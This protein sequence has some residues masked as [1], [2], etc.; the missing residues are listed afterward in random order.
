MPITNIRKQKL[1]IAFLT[2]LMVTLV[3]VSF[4]FA[5]N[6]SSELTALAESTLDTT[7]T[8]HVDAD[9][10]TYAESAVI[11]ASITLKA[12]AVDENVPPAFQSVANANVS[13]SATITLSG[14]VWDAVKS[15]RL[16]ARLVASGT[17]ELNTVRG[18][19]LSKNASYVV[20]GALQG[21]GTFNVANTSFTNLE[22][23]P[24]TKLNESNGATITVTYT[25]Q[26]SAKDEGSG[27]TNTAAET[28]IDGTMTFVLEL[29]FVKPTVSIDANVGGH[30]VDASGEWYTD[31]LTPAEV[32][33]LAFDDSARFTAVPDSGYYF[34]GWREAGTTVN[35]SGTVLNIGE[36]TEIALGKQP[37]F[38]AQFG[39]ISVREESEY[40]F[41]GN[42]LG[43]VIN[44]TAYTGVYY[45]TH[46]Y[47]GTANDGTDFNAYSEG[48]ASVVAGP[49]K[50]GTYTYKCD[51]FYRALEGDTVVSSGERIGGAVI[52][53]TIERNEPI[54]ERGGNESE[55]TLRL[56]DNLSA[57]DM[58]Y[59]ASNSVNKIIAISGALSIRLNGVDV[60]TNALLPVSEEGRRYDVHFI[61][62]DRDNY[63]EV[64]V[65]LTIYVRD[66][67]P[68]S[69]VNIES[70]VRDY[71]ISKSIVTEFDATVPANI[72]ALPEGQEVIKVSLRANM[73]DTSG[74]Y[75]FI[76]WRIGTLLDGTYAYSYLTAGEVIRDASG[77]ISAING[78]DFDYYMPYYGD[79][80]V[81][82]AEKELKKTASFQAIFVQDV[83]C[84]K[85]SN[86]INVSYTGAS[87]FLTPR[88]SPEAAGYQFGFG[89]LNYYYENDLAVAQ[90]KAPTAIG[91]HVLRYEIRNTALNT[92]VDVR[93]IN[94]HIVVATVAV[95]VNKI[96]SI[97]SGGYNEATGW[98]R[99]MSYDLSVQSLV[100][101]GA[102]KYYYS[103]DD[104][105]TWNEITSSIANSLGCATNFNTPS[106]TEACSVTNYL[107]MATHDANGV[108][109]IYAGYKVIARSTA[110][111]TAKIDTVSPTLSGIT[112]MQGGATYQAQW[113]NSMVNFTATASYGGS[114]AVIDVYYVKNGSWVALSGNVSH[115]NGTSTDISSGVE[116]VFNL[117]T[118]YEGEVKFRIRTG[119][120]MTSAE[121]E[122]FEIKIDK[123][124]PTF[125]NESSDQNANSLGWIGT[126]TN[127]TYTVADLGGAG[128]K[129][130]RAYL[131]LDGTGVN[132]A[133]VGSNKY[134]VAILDSREYT[135]EITDNAGNVQITTL[136]KNVDVESITYEY[137]ENS[138]TSGSWAHATAEV[139]YNVKVG[140]S[141]ARLSYSVNGGEYQPVGNGQYTDATVGS[142]LNDVVLSYGIEPVDEEETYSFKIQNRAGKE[143]I[144]DFGVI[145]F[146]LNAPVYTLLT[147][148][149][150]YQ[151]EEWSSVNL[152][153]EFTVVDDTQNVNSGLDDDS[154]SVDNGGTVENLGNGRYRLTIDKCTVYTLTIKD[155]AGNTITDTIQANVDTVTPSLTLNAY[156]GGGNPLDLNEL[157]TDEDN[158]VEN[159]YDFESWI[160]K[161]KEEPYVRIEFT[162]NLTAS[163]SRLEYSNNNG[164]TWTALTETYMP[165]PGEVSG[166]ISTRT[167]IT[168]EQNR[169]YKF[170]LATGSGRT[171]VYEHVDNKDLYVKL[172][173]T[174]PTL[175]SE[176]FR[177]GT[178]P[179]FPLKTTWINQTAQYRIMTADTTLGSGVDQ[180][181]IRLNI[182]PYETPD[183]DILNGTAVGQSVVM[184]V[185]GDYRTYDFNS[186]YKCLLTFTDKAGNAYEGEIFISH[187]DL[188]SGFSFDL[189]TL[190]VAN[191]V[192]SAW[193]EG[194]W[195]ADGENML[196]RATPV[197]TEGNGFG[198]SGGRLEVSI[199]GENW[200]TEKRL[201]GESVQ[202]LETADGYEFLTTA[203]QLYTYYFRLVTGAGSEYRL[204]R[205]YT[206]QKDNV[207]PT[208]QA[209][210][211]FAN[212]GAYGGEWTKEN[213]KFTLRALVG[214]AGGTLKVGK[215]ES[216]DTA[217]W[218][219]VQALAPNV[220]N[221]NDYYLTVEE[222]SNTTYFFKVVGLNGLESV[223]EAGIVVKLDKTEIVASTVAV[224]EGTPLESGKWVNTEA[225]IYPE[226]SAIGASGV[227]VVYVSVNGGE[228]VEVALS[229]ERYSVA[230]NG[231][232]S[233][234]NTYSFKIASVSGMEV[235]TDSFSLGYDDVAPTFTYALS[236]SQLP[237]TAV[238]ANRGWY[239]SDVDVTLTI[240]QVASGYEV[241]YAKKGVND[242][243]YGEWTLVY[244]EFTLTDSS[245]SGG[246]DYYYIF[247]VVSGS[248][249]EESSADARLPIDTHEYEA[250]VVLSVGNILEDETH[251]FATVTGTGKYK[252]G[253]TFTVNVT[254]FEGYILK[255]LYVTEF[256]VRTLEANTSL[257]ALKQLQE[258]ALNPDNMVNKYAG[259]SKRYTCTGSGVTLEYDYYKEVYL[260]YT[261]LRQCLQAGSVIAVGY[262]AQEEGFDE[263]F[264]AVTASETQEKHV[265]VEISYVDVQ[266]NA[267]SSVP[268]LIG[269]Y[270]FKVTPKDGY[271]NYYYM[272]DTAT[273]TVVYFEGEGT[274][275]DPYLIYTLEDFYHIDDY[276]HFETAD[277]TVDTRAYL[278]ANRREAY[279]KQM[280]DILMPSSFKPIASVG[281]G[282][283][284]AFSG[285]YNGNGYEFYYSGTYAV[286]GDFGIFLMLDGASITNL[287][288][289]YNVRLTGGNGASVGLISARAVNSSGI[290]A[291]YTIGNIYA[292]GTELNVGGVV[293]SLS[294]GIVSY[295]F[296]DVNITTGNADGAFG[297]VVGRADG[298]YTANVYTVSRLILNGST[299]YSFTAPSSTKF[300]YAGA[301]IGYIENFDDSGSKPSLSNK[302]YYLDKN[303]SFD[304]SIEIGL[305]LGNKETFGQY[306]E[307]YH[308]AE[309]INYFASLEE[310]SAADTLIVNV[311][312]R[313]YSVS[314]LEL[315]KI[316]IEDLKAQSGLKGDGTKENPFIINSE[317]LLSYVETFPY[318]EFKQEGDITLTVERVFCTSVPFVGVYDGAGY[319][320]LNAKA[321][322]TNDA[323]GGLFGVVAGTVK[324]LK[325]LDCEF[326]YETNGSLYAGGLVGLLE[327]GGLVENVIVTGTIDV[328]SG[329]E[330]AYA[331][332][333]VG[334]V[335]NAT[336]RNSL[337][338]VNVSVNGETMVVGGVCGHLQG[339]GLI[340]NVVSLSSLSVEYDKKANVGVAV[341]S[342]NSASGKITGLSYLTESA[343]A[344]GK[345]VAT[346]VGYSG[347]ENALGVTPNTYANLMLIEISGVTVGDKLKGLY[348]FSGSGT[349]LDPFLIASYEDL[350]LV[351]NYMYASFRLV[352]NVVIGDYNDD[353][354]LDRNDG[355]DY[356]YAPIGNGA[357]F[358]GSLDGSG[359]S[360]IGLTDSLFAVNAGAIS[361]VT[362]NVSYKVYARESDIPESDKVIDAKEG[363]SYTASKVAVRNEDILFGVAARINRTGGSL[364]RVSVSGEIYVRTL[365][366]SKV[367]FG[368]LVGVDMGGQVI[369]SQ[370]TASVSIRAS[371]VVAGGVI[372]EIRYS[373]KALTQIA[374]NFIQ[375]N[376][377]V[378]LGGASVTAGS[379][380]GYVAVF[381]SHAPNYASSTEIIVNG[382]NVGN[383]QYVG[384]QI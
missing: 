188:T 256:G 292:Q 13:E 336:I 161:A 121:S 248:G 266:G 21:K 90:S 88:F 114:G 273:L 201:N 115:S 382:E 223:T 78:L 126:V 295:S 383:G 171:V 297:G 181:S 92:T 26:N 198:L 93:E 330:I 313:N 374:S 211:A 244:E 312:E 80:S 38:V 269:T 267:S 353:G 305:S 338:V 116:A 254:P 270:T 345:N 82:E 113:T 79:E 98:A 48:T 95:N 276:M 235:V 155:I 19:A 381:H 306:A 106:V 33:D 352:D 296:S 53:F 51:F 150:A 43:P 76:G 144:I 147:D 354:I 372:G 208:V 195:L 8:T 350:T 238:E 260:S 315:V 179:N 134:R 291:S 99:L 257:E 197:F 335:N 107:F 328:V 363:V 50:A 34:M 101:K 366:Q 343:Y 173:F 100:S 127:V 274:L 319:S 375:I 317:E 294:H 183:E 355:Y 125:E 268:S 89:T 340:E 348:P 243:S 311:E 215:G 298:A 111:V 283:T 192:E 74:Q 356:D 25:A 202:V 170:R 62:N 271:E 380:V 64:D 176:T 290:R 241:Y 184:A 360:I 137:A 141:G 228:Y 203:E 227:N 193:T 83:T 66:M 370:M 191:D 322:G 247:K 378:D 275:Q 259:D 304:G 46:R 31:G 162:I 289:R 28:T 307:L 284:N 245:V 371:Q 287:G 136:Q 158:S 119:S 265:G 129:S 104:G 152:T 367:T 49:T 149:S 280:D 206:V 103:S 68:E 73:A 347:S 190:K 213:L 207:T 251:K 240:N 342:L 40:S 229:G 117:N 177:V 218:S 204:A 36:A 156:V 220:N 231:N 163:G 96:V 56:G 112:A 57:L 282:Y 255:T 22:I 293:G 87:A 300:T 157:P 148:L 94:Y 253:D 42:A 3:A 55:I 81:L 102:E 344:N 133:S 314:V 151:G 110:P 17:H 124:L 123:T 320:I 205:G 120:G 226:I 225:L 232:T 72:T 258:D 84:G 249:L 185:A 60:D 321:N 12:R 262:K 20:T 165:N 47:T 332:G 130:V 35:V 318:A 272:N 331:G 18:V 71:T 189:A 7:G 153:A 236:G 286:S 75:F 135:V 145:R 233:T 24:L 303:V 44:S 164:V 58:S 263:F 323:F 301:V 252:R 358:T 349:T 239:V 337:S 128:V 216:L 59:K 86:D 288:A 11:P 234:L 122:A 1:F 302:S 351:G 362:L 237:N 30:V 309:D 373:D 131:S 324:N 200:F 4:A 219:D 67:M 169:N 299:R 174:A 160:T 339:A 167:Y 10:T 143:I 108:D 384:R 217:V 327:E 376:D 14:R 329:A 69:G 5:F 264:G 224:E 250:K 27:A 65:P 37:T 281:N 45:L 32:R 222:S 159:L 146:D 178:T 346:S 196:F 6:S 221:L 341:G 61:P 139:V 326:S 279:F 175:R 246:S 277:E 333:I 142:V 138:Y 140:A 16:S 168:T 209:S 364:I 23:A 9:V 118:E 357:T 29:S 368:G 15:G 166:T 308:Q 182:Y 70:G 77:Q 261:N 377:G 316:R 361:D 54:V 334:V 180:D 109:G 325:V 85:N 199:D 230:L 41:S 154:I 242:A 285:S 194:E 212:N 39:L 310:G 379:F 2:L 214:A 278:G 186:A 132:V 52:D 91:E 105:A 187:V 365:G 63:A 97:G 172:D 210:V 369:A 359:Y